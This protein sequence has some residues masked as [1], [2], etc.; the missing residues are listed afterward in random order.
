[1]LVECSPTDKMDRA[2]ARTP[3]GFLEVLERDHEFDDNHGARR[4]A[5]LFLGAD[6][7][8]RPMRRAFLSRAGPFTS[9]RRCDPRS[10]VRRKL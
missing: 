10:W 3:F 6:G 1:M 4:L 9:L 7:I 5:I 2:V 8:A